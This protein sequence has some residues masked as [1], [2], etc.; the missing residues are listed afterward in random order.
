[1][2]EKERRH[3]MEDLIERL[4]RLEEKLTMH[5]RSEDKDRVFILSSLSETR[6]EVKQIRAQLQR[7]GGYVAG[8][9]S[10][11]SLLIGLVIWMGNK[12]FGN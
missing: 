10:A 8:V 6:D 12:V 3:G 9:A 5:V 2:E 11:F 7:Q 1:M 4:V